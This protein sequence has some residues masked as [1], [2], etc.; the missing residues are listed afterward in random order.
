MTFYKLL[1]FFVFFFSFGMVHS[2]SM[3]Q[4]IVTFGPKETKIVG[5]IP[6]SVIGKYKA[7][8]SAFKGRIALDLDLQRVQS[9]YLEIEA[10]SIQS[11]CPWCDK[12]ARSRRLLNTARFPRIIFKS[13]KIIQ[14]AKGFKVNGVLL[15]HGITRRMTFPFKAII[16]IDQN[17]RRKFLELQGSWLIN[18]KDFNIIWNKLLDRGGV[19]VGNTLTVDW[20]IKVVY[21][22]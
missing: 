22:R 5:S 17:T 14:D 18:R 2:Q 7:Q 15:M 21:P 20:G 19:V 8:F 1:T 9:V 3:A 6:Y 13:S 16:I 10:N 12:L 4:G 11:N